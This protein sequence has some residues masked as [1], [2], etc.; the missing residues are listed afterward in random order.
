MPLVG[1][2]IKIEKLISGMDE[3]GPKNWSSMN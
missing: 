3:H 2:L 1:G